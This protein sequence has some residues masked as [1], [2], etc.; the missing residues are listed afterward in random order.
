MGKDLRGKELGVGISQRKDGLYTARFTSKISGKR[1]QKYFKKLQECRNWL[2]DATFMDEHGSI[3]ALGEM[4]LDTWYKY[5]IDNI[6]IHSIKESTKE[7]YERVY[8]NHIQPY[9]GSML[10][11]K[12]KPFN[13]QDI[14]NRL[15]NE[16]AQSTIESVRVVLYMLFD[17]AEDNEIIINNPVK[18]KVKAKSRV[19]TVPRRAM[20]KEE[21]KL[22]TNIIQYSKYYNEF[23]LILQTGIR[24]GEMIGLMWE[25]IDFDKRTLSIKRTARFKNDEII[26][27]APK[28]VNS[29]RTIPL[30]QEA[31]DILCNQREKIRSYKVASLKY[32]EFVFQ[33]ENGRKAQ[34]RTYQC[35][36]KRLCKKNGL[37]NVSCHI[38]RHTYATRCIEAGMKP[39]VLQTLLGHSS[40][41]TTMDLYVHVDIGEKTKEVATIESLLKVV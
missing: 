32:K 31:Y 40:I 24:C 20:T 6:K 13:C 17:D 12:I 8:K 37:D 15:T 3:N 22:F 11:E 7:G 18:K 9:I 36:I 16:Y 5:W 34:N 29:I 39:K 4:T 14:L 25:D 27:T 2:A 33:Y 10:L 23:M 41:K 1:V 38:L 35:A 21:Q 19:V 28:T 30:T 26:L